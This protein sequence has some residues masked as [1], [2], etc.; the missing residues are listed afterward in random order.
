MANKSINTK[1]LIQYIRRY[2]KSRASGLLEILDMTAKRRYSKTAIEL[3][4]TEPRN[5]LDIIIEHYSSEEVAHFVISKLFIRPLA[6]KLNILEYEDELLEA[7][8]NDPHR[9]LTLLKKCG[10]AIK[11][12]NRNR[13]ETSSPRT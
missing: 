11:D 3:L 6:I 7:L 1:L 13:V 12:P 2:I 8:V 5:L 9:F 4:L 10:V